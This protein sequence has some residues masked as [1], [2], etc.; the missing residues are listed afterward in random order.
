MSGAG[1]IKD[2]GSDDSYI[3]E[4]KDVSGSY[5]LDPKAIRQMYVRAVRQGKLPCWLLVWNTEGFTAEIKIVPNGKAMM[6]HE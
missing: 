6:N 5:R 4:V 1:S 3:Y 2:D